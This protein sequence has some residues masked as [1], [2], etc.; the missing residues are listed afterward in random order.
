MQCQTYQVP[1]P[2]E[3]EETVKASL[4]DLCKLGGGLYNYRGP[5]G[6]YTDHVMLAV[7]LF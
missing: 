5:T 7:L 3:K 6:D 1:I 4:V 2:E